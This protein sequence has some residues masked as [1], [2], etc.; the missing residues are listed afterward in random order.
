MKPAPPDDKPDEL[1]DL[2]AKLEV[3]EGQ[4]AKLKDAEVDARAY[5]VS[6]NRRTQSSFLPERA[7][8]SYPRSPRRG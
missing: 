6:R 2:R 1:V 3:A 8:L 4:L 5:S 7:D